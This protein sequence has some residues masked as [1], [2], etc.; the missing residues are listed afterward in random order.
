MSGLLIRGLPERLPDGEKLV[1]QG[2]PTWRSAALHV[3]HVRKAAIYFGVLLAWLVVS[4]QWNGNPLAETAHSFALAAAAAA[5]ALAVL[6]VVAWLSSRTTIYTITD[7]R[8]VLQIGMA[9]PMSINLPFAIIESAALKT[10]PDGAGDIPLTIRKGDRIAYLVLWPHARAWHFSQ[11]EPSLRA[12]PDASRVAEVLARALAAAA[13]QA[14]PQAIA[15]TG[16][17]TRPAIAP[18][19]SVAAAG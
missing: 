6:I 18:G 1:W 12:V 9:L 4:S 7:R 14:A 11:P 19:P 16:R 5:C 15:A 10:H 8:V 17:R 3:F 2:S 13:G